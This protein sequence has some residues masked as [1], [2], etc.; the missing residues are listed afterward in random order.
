MKFTV[1]ESQVTLTFQGME[2]LWALK[3]RLQI[4][5]F[6]ISEVR[7][8]PEAPVMQDLTGH[9]RM[10]GTGLPFAF[11]AGVFRKGNDREFWYV[12][13]KQPGMLTI[14]IKP[15][16]LNYDRI[17]VTCAEDTARA[18]TDWWRHPAPGP[19]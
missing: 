17:R 13:V 16:A 1:Q 15:D 11:V 8:E 19:A 4:P 3:R 5:R 12:R 10:L 2:C 6:A 18:I 14:E 7:Y 9:L